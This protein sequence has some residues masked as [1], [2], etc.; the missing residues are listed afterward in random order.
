MSEEKTGEVLKLLKGRTVSYRKGEC[1]HRQGEPVKN[2]G[3]VLSGIAQVCCDDY[4]GNRVIMAEVRPGRTFGESLCYLGI[5]DPV[6]YIYA[7]EDSDIL[8]LSLD[9][10]FEKNRDDLASEMQKRFITLLATRT[11]QMNNRIQVLSK[12]SIRE[13]LIMYFSELATEEGHGTFTV[14]LNR[15]DLAAYI[16]ANR[17]ALSRELSKMKKEGI[18]DYYGNTFRIITNRP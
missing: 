6:V 11:L 2:F 14:P 18:I 12:L 1:M 4:D 8:W 17:S 16:G 7:S 10:L 3:M 9:R 5:E 13:K 15:E